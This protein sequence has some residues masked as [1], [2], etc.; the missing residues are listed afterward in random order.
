MAPSG[1]QV[2]DY[3]AG[4]FLVVTLDLPLTL[5][6]TVATAAEPFLGLSMPLDPAIIAGGKSCRA[7]TYPGASVVPAGEDPLGHGRRPD[8]GEQRHQHR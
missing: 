8:D 7:T 5:S 2:F 6:I 3:A 1:S 4:Q